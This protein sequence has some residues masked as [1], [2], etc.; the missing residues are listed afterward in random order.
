ML[1]KLDTIPWNELQ[2]AYGSAA[3]IPDNI[4]DLM[5]S[6]KEIRKKALS[7]LYSNIF[8]Q[9]T[10]YNA[11]PYAIPF[12]FELIAN[13]NTE[14]RHKLIYYV[15]HLGLG[16]EYSYLLEGI[17][18]SQINAEL[19]DAHENMSEEEIQNNEDYGYS[20]LALLDCYNFV[21]DRIPILQK[22]IENTPKNDNHKD[23][24]L[25]N[26]AIYALSWFAEKGQESIELIKNQIPVLKH[27]T[28]IANCILAIG[29]LS[30]NTKPK[31]D[32]SF[33][34]YYLDS[35]SLLLQTSAAISLITSPLTNQILE[36]LIQAITSDEELKKI[37]EIP[38]NEGN[39]NGYASEILSNYTQTKKEE[40]KTLIAL[41]Q[42]IGKMNTY[43]AIGTTSSIL[44]ILNKNRTIPIKDTHINDLKENEIIALKAIANSKGWGVGDM[45][46]TNFSSLMRQAGLP[47]SKQKLLDY[48]GGND[49]LR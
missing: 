17:N 25:I 15:I 20:Y 8:H 43:Q 7:T 36:I 23:R 34:E 11:T 40:Q 35:Q 9:G 19:K 12:L 41:S 38:F 21:E 29:L 10:R 42:T 30:K 32:I 24:K 26:A 2:H 49:D 44:T 47:D 31:V 16:Y 33:L 6:D 48:L 4:R 28:D 45:I 5:S 14:D 39:I 22:I 18:P 37:S 1:E 3:D 46:F 27:E 13:E